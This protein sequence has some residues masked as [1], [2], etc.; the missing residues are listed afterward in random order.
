MKNNS[1]RK[2]TQ[3]IDGYTPR[4]VQRVLTRSRQ[5]L[6]RL[7]DIESYLEDMAKVMEMK[8]DDAMIITSTLECIYGAQK[9]IEILL[10]RFA[11]KQTILANRQAL[12]DVRDAENNAQS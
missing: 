6:V 9:S 1:N 3:D 12:N 11:N 8:S 4:S 7:N 5:A 2:L 10:T